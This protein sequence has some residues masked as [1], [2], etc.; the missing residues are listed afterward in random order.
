M[1]KNIPFLCLL[2]VALP[3]SFVQGMEKQ[4]IGPKKITTV[5]RAVGTEGKKVPHVFYACPRDASLDPEKVKKDLRLAI[6]QPNAQRV[7][8]L[9]ACG[10]V[11]VN[12]Q[13]SA[14]ETWLHVAARFGTPE[15]IRL[16]LKAGASKYIGEFSRGKIPAD[17]AKDQ[18]N[19][20]A[21]LN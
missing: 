12:E 7:G 4:E 11:D 9:L 20:D 1:L 13:D 2:Y 3:V 19:R 10:V 18:A 8:E 21:L 6:I 5:P 16:F 17:V 14:G 15:I